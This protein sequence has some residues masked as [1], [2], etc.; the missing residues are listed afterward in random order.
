MMLTAR[1]DRTN[2]RRG[3]KFRVTF[4]VAGL[5]TAVGIH[6]AAAQSANPPPGPSKPAGEAEWKSSP[7]HGVIGGD[8]KVIPCRC[9]YRGTAYKLG[10]KVCMTTPSGSVMTECDLRQN[11][12]SW[13]PTDEVCTTS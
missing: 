2:G 3:I 7:F 11:N 1:R 9:L 10:E 6:A 8:G 4:F 13:V 5:F 12:T